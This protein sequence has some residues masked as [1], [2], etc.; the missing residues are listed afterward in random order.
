MRRKGPEDFSL[1]KESLLISGLIE[2]TQGTDKQQENIIPTGN[3]RGDACEASP[4]LG[5]ACGAEVRGI[6][7]PF[8]EHAKRLR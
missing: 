6:F 1:R 3:D 7:I 5:H 4:F 8:P 2:I